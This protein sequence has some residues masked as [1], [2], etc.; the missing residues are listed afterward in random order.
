MKLGKIQ[1][2]RC[3]LLIR[4]IYI[5]KGHCLRSLMFS[6]HTKL[7][8]AVHL[9][10]GLLERAQTQVFKGMCA[11]QQAVFGT[12]LQE[13]FALQYQFCISWFLVLQ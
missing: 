12:S 6:Q 13:V 4:G 1:A 7:V 2:M 5:K 11:C 3:T 8:K 10:R 9:P